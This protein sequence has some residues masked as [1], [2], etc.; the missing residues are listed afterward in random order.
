MACALDIFED[1]G[2]SSKLLS[3]SPVEAAER[4]GLRGPITGVPGTERCT[5][6][7]PHCFDAPLLRFPGPVTQ[8]ID[9]A[10]AAARLEASSGTQTAR[11][12]GEIV[13]EAVR[14]ADWGI[15]LSATLEPAD[16]VG[17]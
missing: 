10:D 7:P 5:W 3:G 12:L 17:G 16:R 6:V 1:H 2:L 13:V 8:Y 14:A 15:A 11:T 9:G 4:L